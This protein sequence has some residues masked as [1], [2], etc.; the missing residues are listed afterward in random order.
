MTVGSGVLH[1]IIQR[2][3]EDM[4]FSTY[5]TAEKMVGIVFDEM[6]VKNGLVLIGRVEGLLVL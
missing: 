5:T 1:S 6:K 2:I 4:S 3:K